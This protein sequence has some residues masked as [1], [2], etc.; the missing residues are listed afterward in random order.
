MGLRRDRCDSHKQSHDR[1]LRTSH[2]PQPQ[3]LAKGWQ[4]RGRCVWRS[5]WWRTTGL[6]PV[7]AAARLTNRGSPRPSLWR[8][9]SYRRKFISV[10]GSDYPDPLFFGLCAFPGAWAESII[11]H[12]YN[13]RS[14]IVFGFAAI[15][16]RASRALSSEEKTTVRLNSFVSVQAVV[17]V[18]DKR[19]IHINLSIV[20]GL[21]GSQLCGKRQILLSNA[22]ELC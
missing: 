19:V 11:F 8:E 9:S 20:A 1:H 14:P 7:A 22:S 3:R 13:R 17:H 15:T 16:S 12:S 6:N 10:E 2:K 4:C 5:P 18:V 21:G